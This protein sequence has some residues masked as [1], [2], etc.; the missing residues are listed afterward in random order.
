MAQPLSKIYLNFTLET[1]NI[2]NNV[3]STTFSSKCIKLIGI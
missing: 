3:E 1:I 2:N